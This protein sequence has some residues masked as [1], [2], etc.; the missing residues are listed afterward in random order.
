MIDIAILATTWP[1][2]SKQLQVFRP[3]ALDGMPLPENP[4]L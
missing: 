4:F 1:R 2:A 3:L